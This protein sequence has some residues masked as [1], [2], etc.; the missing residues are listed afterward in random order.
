MS[1][2]IF[3]L[4]ELNYEPIF[5]GPL[6]YIDI[7]VFLENEI[8]TQ[9]YRVPIEQIGVTTLVDNKPETQIRL[10]GIDDT[11]IAESATILIPKAHPKD[12]KVW[13]K[14]LLEYKD[15]YKTWLAN[16]RCPRRVLPD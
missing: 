15:Q 6:G 10:E 7:W 9:S 2:R 11:R 8:D 13:H 12:L 14:K 4:D 3:Y 1:S 16:R 5:G